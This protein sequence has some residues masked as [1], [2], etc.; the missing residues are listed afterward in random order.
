[1]K[2]VCSWCHKDMG[3]EGLVTHGICPQCKLKIYASRGTTLHD[4]LENMPEPVAVI[5]DE[6][7]VSSANKAMRS[8][9]GKG[10]DQITD[11]LGGEV[12]SCSYAT[13][14]E[15]CGKTVHCSGCSIRNTVMYT[16]QSGLS[17]QVEVSILQDSGRVFFEI[18]TETDGQVVLLK[19]KRMFTKSEGEK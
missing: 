18:D 6:G 12:F 19:I 2:R 5:T 11:F 7:L 4:F 15:G 9:L 8:A 10:F 3:G 17:Q 13:L 14:P 1:M 16:L